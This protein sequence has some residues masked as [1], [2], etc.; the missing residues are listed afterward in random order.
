M[1]RRGELEHVGKV[2]PRTDS[3]IL[4][5][6]YMEALRAEERKVGRRLLPS[7]LDRFA[8]EYH[9][10]AYGAEVHRLMALGL[11]VEEPDEDEQQRGS[12]A[13]KSSNK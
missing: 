13:A 11:G 12:D 8:R 1:R 10:P 4:Y 2:V 7:E 5:A 9:A 6:Q 3:G